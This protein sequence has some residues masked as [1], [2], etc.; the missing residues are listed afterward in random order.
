MSF[1]S[2][3]SL[4]RINFLT[5]L[6]I[7]LTRT[8]KKAWTPG[9]V[10]SGKLCWSLF[11]CILALGLRLTPILAIPTA[12]WKP[13]EAHSPLARS[14]SRRA[15]S[16]LCQLLWLSMMAS[17]PPSLAWESINLV[18]AGRPARRLTGLWKTATNSSTL[19]RGTATKKAWA[20]P[21]NCLLSPE[22]TFS[23]WRRFTTIGTVIMKRFERFTKAWSACSWITLIC[24]WFTRPYRTRLWQHGRQWLAWKSKDWSGWS[25]LDI[26]IGA[27]LGFSEVGVVFGKP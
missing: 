16:R 4:H 21:C 27:G 15:K 10:C 6:G 3:I 1:L 22:R 23:W 2:K 25:L 17:N 13:A 11:S 8:G 12:H 5:A 20:R 9:Q 7:G 14:S 26:R 24:I 19:L 18:P